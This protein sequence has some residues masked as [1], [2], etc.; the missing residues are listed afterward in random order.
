MTGSQNFIPYTNI[1]FR[2]K[3]PKVHFIFG[4][5]GR[6]KNRGKKFYLILVPNQRFY[7]K[8]YEWFKCNVLASL[9]PIFCLM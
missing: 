6:A 4:I 3:N 7:I 9:I 2:L 5:Y 8:V 1:Y